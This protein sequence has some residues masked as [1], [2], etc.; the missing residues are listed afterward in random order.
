MHIGEPEVAASEPVSE[1]FV[2]D[3]ELLE[4]GG[5]EVMHVHPVLDNVVDEGVGAAARGGGCG[6]KP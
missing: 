5:L 4:D 1:P 6:Y 3:A 2:V